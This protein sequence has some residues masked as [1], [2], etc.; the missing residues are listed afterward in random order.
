MTNRSH[1]TSRAARRAEILVHSTKKQLP[2]RLHCISDQQESM[3][4]GFLRKTLWKR[5]YLE[6]SLL[7]G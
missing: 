4:I 5:R 1:S 2:W 3:D 7:A 6:G